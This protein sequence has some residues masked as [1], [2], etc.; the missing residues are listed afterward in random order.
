MIEFES[1]SSKS[2]SIS[3]SATKPSSIQIKVLGIGGAGCNILSRINSSF[4]ARMESIAVNTDLRCLEKC[5]TKKRLQLGATITGG[6][7]AGGDA[8]MGRRIAL[9]E[10]EKIKQIVQGANLICLIFGLGKGTGTG[11]SPVIGR[12]AKEL[13]S[14]TMGFAILP[15]DFE[16][17]KRVSLAKKS[18]QEMEKAV[19]ALMV[20]PN[21]V[22][23]SN[24]EKDLSLQEGFG[25][26]DG[27]MEKTIHVL[28]N[29]LLHSGLIDIDFADFKAFLQKKG[30]IQMA[31][32]RAKG[33]GAAKDAAKQAIS[34]PL[35]ERISLKKAKGVLFNI[36]GG[37]D[38]SLSEVEKAALVIREAVSPGS[39]IVFGAAIDENL[40][41][42][43]SLAF[44]AMGEETI[45]GAG[46]KRAEE[47]YQSELD[48]GVYED[49]LDI[50]T[51]LRKRK[52]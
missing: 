4:P 3:A 47:S 41:S 36:L 44:I 31:I 2:S 18:I 29:L 5:R 27:I 14:L 33:Q 43:V 30:H 25:R 45:S 23:L 39:E 35:M 11:V 7:G 16:G 24:P 15:F 52:N 22:L 50:P 38:L 6:W 42:E 32:G 37:K 9:E 20:I 12:L 34:S 26:I 17:E 1:A 13:G 46:R 28:D 8:E 21:D 10:K 51:F 48:L 40:S 49:N 19:D